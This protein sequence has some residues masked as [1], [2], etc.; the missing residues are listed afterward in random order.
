MYM[1]KMV[2][3]CILRVENKK[4]CEL[5]CTVTGVLCV[6]SKVRWYRRYM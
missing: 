2:D 6:L 5:R 1:Y 4:F 3:V